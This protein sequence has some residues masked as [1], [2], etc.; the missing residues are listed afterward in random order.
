[1][2]FVDNEVDHG[3]IIMQKPVPVRE[4]DDEATLHD[5]IKTLEHRLLVEVCSLFLQG[6]VQREGGRVRILDR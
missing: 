1:V 5:R 4:H 2:H 6:R 3:P